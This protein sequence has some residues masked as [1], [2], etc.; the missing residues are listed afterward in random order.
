MRGTMMEEAEWKQRH[1]WEGVREAFQ[2]GGVGWS[3]RN[4]LTVDRTAWKRISKKEPDTL[5]GEVESVCMFNFSMF[6]KQS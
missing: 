3:K 5:Q 6:G 4:E 2:K 1:T